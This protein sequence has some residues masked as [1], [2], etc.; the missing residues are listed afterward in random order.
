MSDVNGYR[1]LVGARRGRRF[2]I[3]PTSGTATVT[4]ATTPG[5]RMTG[6]LLRKPRVA[7]LISVDFE[8]L[9]DLLESVDERR[10]LG[11]RPRWRFDGDVE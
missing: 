4:S 1:I 9:P 10:L 11:K 6:I 5:R 3:S 7:V 2:V 8:Q